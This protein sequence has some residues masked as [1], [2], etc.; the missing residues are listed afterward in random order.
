M[1]Y[2]GNLAGFVIFFFTKFK[3]PH[4][5]KFHVARLLPFLK[6]AQCQKVKES[7]YTMFVY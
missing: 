4:M 7:S 2:A 1:L 3:A 6:F 5:G